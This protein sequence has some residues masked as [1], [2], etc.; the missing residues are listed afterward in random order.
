MIQQQL[1]RFRLEPQER[2]VVRIQKLFVL[3]AELF[4]EVLDQ[5]RNV[6]APVAQ[7]RQIDVD[8]VEPVVE[9]LAEFLFFHHLAQVGI[10]GRQNPHVH[11]HHF[12]RA[13]RREFLL[14]NHAQQL[15]LRFRPDGAHFV[16]KDRA[17]VGDFERAF[18]VVN[19]AGER[20]FHMPEQS[21]FQQIGGQR[22][23][24]HGDKRMI[25]AR[26]IGM[27]RLGDQFLARAGFAGDQNGRT[28]RRHL[29]HQIEHAQHAV[30]LADDV[31][32]TVALLERA[33]ELRILI[34]QPL[35]GNDA[36]DFDQQ[37]F[38]VPGLGEIIVG[39]E[40]HRLHRGFHACRRR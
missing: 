13:E 28:A 1:H 25:H 7:R 20:A 6:F 23:A 8:D 24:V 38:V 3:L 36:V 18:L 26:R 17:F 10:G 15:R 5:Q 11:L 22:T 30:A 9:I 2:V 29:H 40:F 16:E 33:L 31:G 34:D 37:L 32:E 27:N 19:G 12:V 14:L 4:E 21:G 35:A 39:A